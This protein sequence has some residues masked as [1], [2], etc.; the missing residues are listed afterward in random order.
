MDNLKNKPLKSPAKHPITGQ[1][2]K[3]CKA[4]IH[5][6]TPTGIFPN[7][8]QRRA[9]LQK[10]GRRNTIIQIVPL[11]EMGKG[12]VGQRVIQHEKHKQANYRM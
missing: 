9:H 2:V 11:F 3:A 5:R 8:R 12:I 6:F 4:L 1:L 7:R 10:A